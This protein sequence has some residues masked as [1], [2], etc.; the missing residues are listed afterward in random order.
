M[1]V[2]AQPGHLLPDVGAAPLGDL[3]DDV[4]TARPRRLALVVLGGRRQAVQ[5]G[6]LDDGHA[7]APSAIGAAAAAASAGRRSLRG[8]PRS[9]SGRPESMGSAARARPPGRAATTPATTSPAAALRRTTSRRAPGSPWRTAS[10]M[11]AF[12]A[13][14]PPWSRAFDALVNPSF[15][16]S[17]VRT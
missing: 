14:E 9:S 5:V 7:G 8:R 17:T 1:V 15:A 6:P 10:T 12:S 11:T 2:Q 4:G 13:G 16:A 3:Q